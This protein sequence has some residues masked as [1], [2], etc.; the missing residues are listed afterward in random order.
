[1]LGK[2]MCIFGSRMATQIPLTPS[3]SFICFKS[4]LVLAPIEY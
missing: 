2:F 4:S 1:M 3:T